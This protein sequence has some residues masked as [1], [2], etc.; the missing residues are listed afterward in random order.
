MPLNLRASKNI[1][2]FNVP[3]SY[4]I[5]DRSGKFLD[6]KNVCSVQDRLDTRY[7]SSRL[8]AVSLGGSIKSL[9]YFS[10][11]DGSQYTI[12]K[13]G[14][15][16]YSVA[17][18]GA[19][20]EIVFTP[21]N[22][23]ITEESV[24]R[25]IT[26]NDR[27]IIAIEDNGLY[28]W[29][30]ITFSRLGQSKPGVA[31]ILAASI[32]SGS[33]ITANTYK[34]AYTFYAPSL[35]FESNYTESAEIT[36]T[37][38]NLTITATGIPIVVENAFVTKVNIYLKNVTTDSAYL[39]IAE[40]NLNSTTYNITGESTSSQTPPINN[41]IP[42]RNAFDLNGG[43]G[44]K[45]LASFNSRLVYAGNNGAPNEVYFSEENLP[46]AFNSLDT[47]LVLPIPGKGP[48]TGLA[49]G[50]FGDTVLDPFLVIFKR[51][52]TRIYS[53]I[54]GEPKMVVLSEE[55]GCV[56]HDT[57]Q[58]K[59]GVVY[60]LSEEGFRA[61]ANGRLVVDKQGDAITLGNGDIDDIFKTTGHVYEVN[62]NGLAKSFSVYYPT[63]DQYMT[64]VS[65]GSNAAYTKTYVYEFNVGGF[66]PYE[67]ASAATCA[68]LGENTS[69]RDM[70]LFGTSDGFVM[71]HSIIEERSDRDAAN[72]EVSINAFAVLP[73][74]PEDGDDDATYNFREL[75]LKAIVSSESLTVKTF[76]N[77]NLAEV[78]EGSYDFTDPED[79]FILDESL[80]DE[81]IFSDGRTV[82]TARSDINRVGESIAI[83]FYQNEI[84]TNIGLVS[85]QIDSS[86]N[87][88]RN[89]PQDG[90]DEEGGFDS[91]TNTY[92]PSVSASVAAA[93]ASAAAAAALFPSGGTTGDYLEKTTPTIV[94]WK[95]GAL[96]GYSARFS[97]AFASLGLEDTIA[98][99][100]DFSYLAPLI[101]LSCSPAQSVR[102]K[103]AS[104]ASVNMS[105]TTTKRSDDIAA[106]THYRNG[107][108]VNTEAAPVAGGGV[109]TFTESTPF[110]DTMTFYSRVSDGTTTVQSNTVTYPFVYPYYYGADVPGLSAANV[111]L[112][113]KSIISSTAS[114]NVSFTTLNGNVY[115][116]AYPAS[117]GALT[118]IKDENNFETFGDWTLTTANITGLDGN[119]V[120]YRIYEFNNPVVAL[121]TNYT[122]IR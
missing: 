72:T 90:D 64:W 11:S 60:F 37:A 26:D 34:V 28:S 38:P 8:N 119:P 62:R 81:G 114:L 122:F 47:G 108:L 116:F 87:G 61:V 106:V 98:K 31:P 43:I 41:D 32:A 13:V 6:A 115:Y 74:L 51:K 17:E 86:K 104:V 63:L 22:G 42:G 25:G 53:E 19:P 1:G 100:L 39:F 15:K 101:S 89:K 77:Y 21:S 107:V 82:V 7:G 30:G 103:G 54:G 57:I 67:F 2:S 111:A 4:R 113:T 76:I 45:Y 33:L 18:T 96:S 78:A 84:A 80:L 71:K 83:G 24:H 105:A 29:D 36:L 44:A 110:T 65:E 35:G 102:E 48:V 5:H 88:N 79:G 52:S 3:V 69:G 10:K 20:V 50:L 56:S 85:M 46:D 27:H 49:V 55:I 109:E 94:S 59:N 95:T 97:E 14:T 12:A 9:S 91:E 92:Y 112:L 58:V 99:I 68:V 118:S 121:T 70:V 66:K 40:V 23:E 117:Y 75:I 16:L 93:A 120:S 73:W